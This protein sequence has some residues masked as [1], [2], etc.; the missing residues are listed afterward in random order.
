[1]TNPTRHPG[2]VRRALTLLATGTDPQAA[3]QLNAAASDLDTRTQ[4]ARI[5]HRADCVLAKNAAATQLI[6]VCDAAT[7]ARAFA[8]AFN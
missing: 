5:E 3:A 7:T 6:E 8:L 1:M 2:R 4:A